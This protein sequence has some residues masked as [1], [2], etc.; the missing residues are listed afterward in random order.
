MDNEELT[1]KI[2]NSGGYH[3]SK[4]HKHFG[5]G[6]NYWHPGYAWAITR[7]AYEKIGGLYESAILGSGDNIMMLALLG[8][9]IKSITTESTNGYK[10]SVIKYEKEMRTLRYG[11]VP[12]LIY[13]YFHGSKK[14]RQYTE[15]WKILSENNFDP[16]TYI[17]YD[18]N[19]II[20]PTDKFPEKLV[21]GIMVYFKERNEDEY[22]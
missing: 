21:L 20:I 16:L 14:N 11:Y 4:G 5:T 1:M 18:N 10:E 15:R 2:F 13:H 19:G 3:Y 9:V 12:G 17:K 22:L 7:K 8:N 6:I